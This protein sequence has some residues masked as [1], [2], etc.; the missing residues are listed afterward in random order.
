MSFLRAIA[1]FIDSINEWVGRGVAWVTLLLVLVVFV[2][3]VMR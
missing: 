3:V 1:D 2:D